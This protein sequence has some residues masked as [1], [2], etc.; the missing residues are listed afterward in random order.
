MRIFKHRNCDI[1]IQDAWRL[2]KIGFNS[3]FGQYTC[4]K[5]CNI[6]H[7]YITKHEHAKTFYISVRLLENV[8]HF[9]ITV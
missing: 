4:L 2:E 9:I 6:L 7:A 3:C 5:T 8:V 1:S